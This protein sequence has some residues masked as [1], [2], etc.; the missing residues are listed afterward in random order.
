MSESSSPAQVKK[1][2][3][4][5]PNRSLPPAPLPVVPPL[6]APTDAELAEA[7]PSTA[8][9]S[10]SSEPDQAAAADLSDEAI[11]AASGQ[12]AVSGTKKA[13]AVS[14]GTESPSATSVTSVKGPLLVSP[15]PEPRLLTAG[16]SSPLTV[17][18]SLQSLSGTTTPV[19]RHSPLPTISPPKPP[20]DESTQ[21]KPTVPEQLV[22]SSAPVR[23]S[24]QPFRLPPLPASREA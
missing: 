6:P 20:G 21:D 18:P 9:T 3:P 1:P 14:S 13:A 2:L 24:P 15:L 17:L 4:K 7:H 16:R 19:R 8:T 10:C 22:G 5:P 11:S 12:T 23:Q